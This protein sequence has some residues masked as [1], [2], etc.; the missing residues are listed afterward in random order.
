MWVHPFKES[1][2]LKSIQIFETW[3]WRNSSWAWRCLRIS[4][5]CLPP[6]TCHVNMEAAVQKWQRLS[7][8]SGKGSSSTL[9]HLLTG[10]TWRESTMFPLKCWPVIRSQDCVIYAI[11]AAQC[12]FAKTEFIKTLKPSGN[13][14]PKQEDKLQQ[15]RDIGQLMLA[16][17]VLQYAPV[18]LKIEYLFHNCLIMIIIWEITFMYRLHW[19]ETNKDR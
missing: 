12:T 19:R 9:S 2:G 3:L 6:P 5:T 15:D 1:N 4:C 11:Q 7:V 13:N 18:F 8:S 17:Y 16:L 10:V 14:L